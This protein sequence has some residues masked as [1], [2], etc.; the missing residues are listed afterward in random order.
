M[1]Q[2]ETAIIGGG[3]AGL[4]LSYW[5]T[6]LGRDHLV[7]ERGRLAER[8][9]SERWD[10]LTL[11]GPNWLLELPGYRYDGPDPD[12]FM[13][14]DEVVGLLEAYAARFQPPL[15]C[16]VTV[17]ELRQS[18]DGRFLLDT[19]A[20]SLAATNVVLATG[21]FQQPKIPAL[22][23]ALPP[24]LLQLTPS[25]YR[26]PA[27]LPAGA[28]LV[29]GSGSS[30]C[31]ITEE[32]CESGRQV[33]L[34]VGRCRRSARRYR[35]QD[36]RYWAYHMGQFERTVDALPSLAARD[37]CSTQVTG[38]R[39]G[40]ELDYR[41]FALDGVVLLGHLEAVTAGR[42]QFADDLTQTLADWDASL[43]E[44]LAAFDAYIEQAGIAAPPD[45][46]PVGAVPAGWT[47]Q[48]PPQ[49]LDSAACGI[50]T[51]MWAT[52]YRYDLDW[53][54]LPV[55]D[56]AGAP[57]Q[58]RGVTACPG[59]YFLGLKF[60]HKLKSSFIYG[61]GDDAAYLARRISGQADGA[62]PP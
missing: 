33:Y 15:R 43:R 13:P 56:S 57:V 60:Q 6:Q 23:A 35:G 32:L 40:H 20:G 26:N 21:P 45:D 29:V 31:Q 17:T 28:V 54:K 53:V 24:T 11:L 42:L 18:A 61:V 36:S 51:V 8:W 58:R 41:R 1:E 9:R 46:P 44:E 27:Q 39:G 25:A 19:S 48:T 50:T 3:Q 16:G 7:L 37:R 12:G 49:H 52:G 55:F 14:K 47:Y 22:S 10:S 38:V 5:L 34:A 30:G 4:T 2:I 59:L 62:A